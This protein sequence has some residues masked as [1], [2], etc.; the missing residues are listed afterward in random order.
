MSRRDLNLIL[1]QPVLLSFLLSLS[2]LALKTDFRCVSKSMMVAGRNVLFIVGDFFKLPCGEGAASRVSG[3]GL[4]LAA[5]LGSRCPEKSFHCPEP[6]LPHY[7][8][9][10]LEV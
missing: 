10:C 7:L 5:N 8:S 4:V 9:R 1:S 2:V 3:I 6:H